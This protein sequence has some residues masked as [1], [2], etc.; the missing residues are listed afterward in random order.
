MLLFPFVVL[1]ASF[2]ILWRAVPVGA[3][4]SRPFGLSTFPTGANI[5]ARKLC[6]QSIYDTSIPSRLACVTKF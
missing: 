2:D 3:P 5:A 1:F 4:W 6:V